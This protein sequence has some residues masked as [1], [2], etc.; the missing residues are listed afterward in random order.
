MGLGTATNLVRQAALRLLDLFYPGSCGACRCF[1][2][3]AGSL[4]PQCRS[5]LQTQVAAPACLR[6]A[7]P[8]AEKGTPCP[9]CQGK[10][11]YPYRQILRLGVYEEP[12][13]KLIHGMKYEHR[14]PLAE[15]LADRLLQKPEAQALLANS[16]C[17][18]PVPL[19]FRRHFLRGYNQAEVIAR[20]FSQRMH[21]RLLHPLKRVRDTQSQTQLHS[22]EARL[23]NVHGAFALRKHNLIQGLH[24]VVVD[25][26]MTSGAT[27]QA[28]GRSLL[29]AAPASLSAII[30]AVVD[31][32]GMGF[33][34]V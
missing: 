23:K 31:P 14:W 15:V 30:L 6:C 4:C 9:R 26:V 24:L 3:G 8:I 11:L 1:F 27:L 13:R 25:D 22:R 32:R 19:H 28:V 5:A 2:G 21:L 17:L 18:V 29:P 12:L 10:G 16:Q 7:A 33:E 34:V 20:R